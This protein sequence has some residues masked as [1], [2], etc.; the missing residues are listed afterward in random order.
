LVLTLTVF[1]NVNLR[2]VSR[3]PFL[4]GRLPDGDGPEEPVIRIDH[5]LPEQQQKNKTI[6]ICLQRNLFSFIG[7]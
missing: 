3:L 6:E 1:P 4:G 5:P 7:I 2:R